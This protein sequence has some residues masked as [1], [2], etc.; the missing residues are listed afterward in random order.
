MTEVKWQNKAETFAVGEADWRVTPKAYRILVLVTKDEPGM[1][2][3]VALNLP[4]AGSCGATEA[5]ALEN[6]REAIRGVLDEYIESGEG[7]PWKELTG[8]VQV[9]LGGKKLWITVDA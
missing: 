9:P 7:I 1:F 8:S 3:A 5:E 6:A 4:G 2:S